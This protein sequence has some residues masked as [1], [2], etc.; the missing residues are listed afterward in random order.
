M[1][2]TKKKPLKN[3]YYWIK[4]SSDDRKAIIV[5]IWDG[6]VKWPD[7]SDSNIFKD[8]YLKNAEWY[9]PLKPPERMPKGGEEGK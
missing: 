5:G 9:G 8:P 4:E 6:V 3:G 7:G 2:W 1:D